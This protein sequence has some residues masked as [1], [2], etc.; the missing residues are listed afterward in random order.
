MLGVVPSHNE[1][2]T[3]RQAV[4][5]VLDGRDIFS[6]TRA[7]EFATHS[8]E[9]CRRA[10]HNT[11][12]VARHIRARIRL[13]V[14]AQQSLADAV[15]DISLDLITADHGWRDIFAGLRARRDRHDDVTSADT[16]EQY[17]RYLEHRETA[18][19]SLYRNKSKQH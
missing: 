14:V 8:A 19:L 17:L 4:R 11:A 6:A 1:V 10:A 12:Q 5:K 16:V 2:T 7:A 18:L 13:A 3:R 15:A 9:D